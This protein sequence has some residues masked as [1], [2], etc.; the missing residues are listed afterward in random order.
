M[1]LLAKMHSPRC[2]TPQALGTTAGYSLHRKAT[3]LPGQKPSQLLASETCWALI[4]SESQLPCELVPIFFKARNAA[5]GSLSTGWVFTASPAL[6]KNASR[7]PRHSAIN[8]SS[9]DHWP[10]LAS[11]LFLS[12]LVWWKI[13]GPMMIWP[14]EPL[15]QRQE[16]CI[17]RNGCGHLCRK[18]LHSQCRYT[19]QCV[20]Q[21]MLRPTNAGNTMT[22]L[23]IITFNQLQSKQLVCMASPLPPSSLELSRKETCW[24]FSQPQRGKVAPPASVSGRSEG[25]LLAYWP[26]CNFDLILATLSALTS[27]PACHLPL[28]NE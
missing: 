7:F 11:P 16:P 3:P 26:V 27:V 25:T 10:A 9:N 22:F 13:D 28:F 15:V 21:L 17:G 6:I 14:W 23:T 19:R 12:P 8:S 4:S 18:S 1:T 20:Q 2:L 24:H 5:V